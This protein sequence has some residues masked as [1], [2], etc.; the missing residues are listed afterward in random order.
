MVFSFDGQF[1]TGNSLTEL[2]LGVLGFSLIKRKDKLSF[3]SIPCFALMIL[4]DFSF[5]PIRIEYGTL[6]LFIMTGFFLA[7]IIGENYFEA[8]SIKSGFDV[9]E[10]YGPKKVRLYKNLFSSSSLVAIYLI[11]FMVWRFY[12]EWPIFSNFFSFQ[13]EQCGILTSLI[14]LLYSGKQGY[15]NKYL[16]NAFYLYYPLHIIIL[17]LIYFFVR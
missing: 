5:F 16:N 7:E 11:F 17:A 13:I 12:P 9:K 6:G 3:L 4:S 14:I 1:Y 2:G 8:S 15:K 10:F